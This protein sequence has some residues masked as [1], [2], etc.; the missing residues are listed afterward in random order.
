MFKTMR[1][2]IQTVLDRDPAAR[3]ALE[4]MICYSGYH[5]IRAHRKA[6]FLWTHGF[7]FLARCYSTWSR[8]W[9]GIEIHP[10]ATIGKRLFIDHGMGVVIGETTIIGDDCTIY[11]GATLGGTGK[12][13]GKRHPT[14]GNNV[15]V[16]C[17]AKVL[18]PFKVG[19]NVK[20]GAGSVVLKEIPDNCTVVGIP[21]KI[22]KRTKCAG[23]NPDGTFKCVA[24][25]DTVHE[26]FGSD[27]CAVCKD[28]S[29][30]GVD[31]GNV[32]KA[33]DLNQINIPDPVQIELDAL[34]AKIKK[35]EKEVKDK[36]N[37]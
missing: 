22:V 2:D 31:C 7:K 27:S 13:V 5:A 16:S 34:W 26:C 21:G 6:H 15:M 25:P 35:L 8:F 36:E 10:G 37:N 14:L 12:D 4:V 17:G 1:E 19:N 3:N 24:N 18:G 28:P 23:V 30:H 9:T 32:E 20:I 29:K 11:Q 33:E